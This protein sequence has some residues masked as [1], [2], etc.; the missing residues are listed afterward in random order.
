MTDNDSASEVTGAFTASPRSTAYVNSLNRLLG[1]VDERTVP[2]GIL[3]SAPATLFSMGRLD[4]AQAFALSQLLWEQHYHDLQQG[5]VEG[6]ESERALP[7]LPELKQRALER[8]NAGTVPIAIFNLRHHVPNGRLVAAV[9]AAA[10]EDRA[11]RPPGDPRTLLEERR[12]Y[13]ACALLPDR[14]ENFELLAPRHA[15]LRVRFVLERDFYLTNITGESADG[16]SV[17]FADGLGPRA[18]AVGEPVEVHYPEPGTKHLRV[19]QHTPAGELRAAFVLDVVEAVDVQP[20][21]SFAVNAT[22]P[23]QGKTNSG[24]AYV[25]Y[26]SSGAVKH[27]QLVNPVII[28]EGFPG[29]YS[30]DYLYTMLNTEGTLTAL[31]AR[32]YDIVVLTY[33][34]PGANGGSDYIQ[35]SAFVAVK[36]IQ[37]VIARRS[38]AAKLV[39]GGA[40]MGGVITRYALA[41]MERNQLAHQ[42]KMFFS[43]DS[44][45]QGANVPISVQWFVQALSTFNAAAAPLATLLRSPAAQQMLYAWVPSYTYSGPL[46]TQHDLFYAELKGLGYPHGTSGQP[47]STVAIAD[48]AGNGVQS[49]PD[50]AHVIDWY[51]NVCANGDTWAEMTGSGEVAYIYCQP[52]STWSSFSFSVTNCINYDGAPGGTG[53]ANGEL[54]QKLIDS[55]YGWVDHH[56]DINCFIPSVSALDVRGAASPYTP[57]PSQGAPSEFGAYFVSA[58]NNQHVAIT[59]DIFTFLLSKLPPTGAE[60]AG[61]AGRADGAEQLGYA[62]SAEITGGVPSF[63]PYDVDI[64]ADGNTACVFVTSGVYVF[65][66]ANETWRLATKL[67]TG[68]SPGYGAVN[69]D[70]TVIVTSS[71]ALRR[72]T[73]RN[74][75][76]WATSASLPLPSLSGNR[77]PCCLACSDDGTVVVV[78]VPEFDRSAP[79]GAYVFRLAAGQ[80]TLAA[81]LAG[82]AQESLFGSSVA[83]GENGA[84][85]VV[86]GINR[87][88]Y[89]YPNGGSAYVF[90]G[91]NWGTRT[92]LPPPGTFQPAFGAEC[93]I[94]PDGSIVAVV[95]EGWW[96][97]NEFKSPG[98]IFVYSGN[99]WQTRS[100]VANPNTGDYKF[101]G[102][103][104]LSA[105]GTLVARATGAEG[106]GQVVYVFSRQGSGW[107]LAATPPLPAPAAA[108]WT[109]PLALSRDGA[110][111][112]VGARPTGAYA[113]TG[114]QWTQATALA[115]PVDVGGLEFG[116]AVSVNEKGS[117][118]LI[119]APGVNELT[120]AAF[121]YG[122]SGTAWKRLAEIAVQGAQTADQLGCAVALNANADTAAVGMR[123]EDSGAGCV[124]VLSGYAWSDQLRV[125]AAVPAPGDALGASLALSDDASVLAAGAPGAGERRGAVVVF[126]GHEWSQRTTLA[127]SGGQPGDHCGGAVALSADGSVIV[128][129]APNANG[130]LGAAYVWGGSNWSSQT[131]LA[132]SGLAA[133]ASFGGSVCV[134]SDG[135][136]VAVGAPG[137]DGDAGAVYVFS[138]SNWAQQ[139]RVAIVGHPGDAIGAAVAV[140]GDGSTLLIGA[141]GANARAGAAHLASGSGHTTVVQLTASDAAVGDGFGEAVALDRYG[142]LVCVGAPGR[143]YGAGVVFLFTRSTQ[144][145]RASGLGELREL[146]IATGRD[147]I[148]VGG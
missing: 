107:A 82:A 136:L 108:E 38:G 134:S 112:L 12:G 50:R 60:L 44:P 99:G 133:D 4:G 130:G 55:D 37:E 123:G 104:L 40:S 117:C 132:P 31:L 2:S 75:V 47:L 143:S 15:G 144:R 19:V 79:G 48:G 105:D 147:R 140:S 28:S 64:S 131:A 138:G 128:A 148:P 92:A 7:P 88:P 142:D 96:F 113:L 81:S 1:L 51:G 98:A 11:I 97:D 67:A 53:P 93:A 87:T 139:A 72:V 141:P 70:G 5:A 49:I 21:T 146:R 102:S 68:V 24:I 6:T 14:F 66:C 103:P 84:T 20:D 65:K 94:S 114:P 85:V 120:G 18:L 122:P 22:I 111:I 121:A 127:P 54:A 25:L 95:D 63:S 33:G 10:R 119:G 41:Y 74:G 89:G 80:W 3:H 109:V 29:G 26:G 86:S 9:S 118:V 35:R 30:W 45:Q 116:A 76:D 91:Q 17:D 56:Y 100:A 13:T 71:V 62:Q 137:V 42:T 106:K 52:L 8:F 46:G 32:G 101:L 69:G 57:I 27:T 43:F 16:V 61:G 73:V 90:T 126:S 110:T 77:L 115:T 36:C 39:V 58:S 23:Y 124:Y 145:P 125:A 78:G 59:H 83:I 34:Q 135:T 129:G